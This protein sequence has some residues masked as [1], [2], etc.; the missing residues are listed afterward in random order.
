MSSPSITVW[1]FMN[2]ISFPLSILT[3]VMLMS[4]IQLCERVAHNFCKIRISLGPVGIR[5]VVLIIL[6]SL[7]LF[8]IE[9]ATLHEMSLTKPQV[10]PYFVIIKLF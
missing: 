1:S 9:S 5:L 3:L 6:L 10:S 7:G 2:Y 8:A 4:G